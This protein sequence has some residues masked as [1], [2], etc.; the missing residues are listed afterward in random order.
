MLMLAGLYA[1]A[2]MKTCETSKHT[3]KKSKK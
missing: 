1:I 3:I 2:Q